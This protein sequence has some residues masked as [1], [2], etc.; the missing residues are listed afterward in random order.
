MDTSDLLNA[1]SEQRN[2]ALNQAAMLSAQL[3]AAQKQIKA[4]E[5]RVN[6]LK[7]RVDNL[8]AVEDGA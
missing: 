5:D 4:L 2:A 8:P 1:I 7:L 3:V 6:D